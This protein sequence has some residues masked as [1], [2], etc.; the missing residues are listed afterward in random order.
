ML[1]LLQ[2]WP[3][4][5]FYFIADLIFCVSNNDDVFRKDGCVDNIET[6]SVKNKQA[7]SC[8]CLFEVGGHQQ[9]NPQCERVKPFSFDSGIRYFCTGTTYLC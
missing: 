9:I 3:N 2:L 1:R 5:T 4:F 8:F 6:H 7:S